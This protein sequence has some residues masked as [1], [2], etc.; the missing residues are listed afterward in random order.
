MGIRIY[1]AYTPGTRNRALS[2]FSN[3]TKSKPE[4]VLIT[5]NH[6][7]KGKIAQKD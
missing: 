2:D 5:K 4:R 7:K 6:R 1:K 3:I